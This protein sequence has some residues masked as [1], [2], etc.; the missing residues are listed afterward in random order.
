MKPNVRAK[1]LVVDDEAH[2]R[3][4]LQDL[5]SLMGY[6][7]E[8]AGSGREALQLLE[9]ESY[10]LMVLDIRMPGIGGVEVMRRIQEQRLDLP[11]VVLTA[12]ASLN[13][14]IA[15]IK[16]GAVDYLQKPIDV[17]DLASTIARTLQEREELLHRQQVLSTISKALNTLDQVEEPKEE[18]AEP[19]P[20]MSRFLR[21][22]PLT[23]D[24][25]KKLAVLNGKPARTIELTENET[26]ILY[27]LMRNANEVL[28]CAQLA[29]TALGYDLDKQNAQSTVRP[30]IHRLRRKIE[31]DLEQP[32]LIQ[33]V[34]G[35]GYFFS[36]P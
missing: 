15:A 4:G 11:I 13:S 9:R 17:E 30:C 3:A 2:I 18:P 7:V 24:T 36:S 12:H 33:T 10:D 21:T 34:R 23:L 8:E 29:H 32:S 20:S 25:Q 27:V 28:S 19:P 16:A 22:G 31:P 26:A 6:H 1:L 14:A 35:R 5:L